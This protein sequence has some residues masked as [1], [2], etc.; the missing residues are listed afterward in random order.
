ML[1]G[2]AIRC[3]QSYT[4]SAP[5]VTLTYITP[6]RFFH[7]HTHTHTH[8]LTHFAPTGTLTYITPTDS[9]SHTPS[10][11]LS[12][13]LSLTPL[14]LALSR[15]SH[16]QT[17]THR[18]SLSPSHSPTHLQSDAVA[19][20]RRQDPSTFWNG[21]IYPGYGPGVDPGPG[22]ASDGTLDLGLIATIG[23]D[24]GGDGGGV[25]SGGRR[26]RPGLLTW[27]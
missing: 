9:L 1:I 5:T 7:T 3:L 25:C 22:D 23:G 10:L 17:L 6:C 12:L 15:T 16:P 24:G 14:P 4:H 8:P 26:G 13:A 2:L 18:L 11:T 19:D 21:V 27:A 20:S